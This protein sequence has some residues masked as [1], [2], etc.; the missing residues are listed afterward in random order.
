MVKKMQKKLK[1]HDLS[2]TSIGI[3]AV[4]FFDWVE[5]SRCYMG[6][7]ERY[8]YDLYTLLS[9]H[10]A[11]IKVVQPSTREFKQSFKDMEVIGVGKSTDEKDVI[12][13]D[14]Q[15]AL[16]SATS[17]CDITIYFSFH[18]CRDVRDNSISISHGVYWDKDR[19]DYQHNLS[20]IEG[21]LESNTTIVS[22]D[23][24]TINSIHSLFPNKFDY[25]KFRYIPNYVD[26]SKFYPK[27]H[28]KRANIDILFPRRG[29]KD[30][31]I[32]VTLEVMKDMADE[33]LTFTFCGTVPH[34]YSNRVKYLI[35]KHENISHRLEDM[36]DM[37]QV[38][39]ETDVSIIPTLNSEGISLSLLEAMASGHIV[40]SSWTGGLSNVVIDGFNGFLGP[41]SA[42]FIKKR[43]SYIINN[44]SDRML[45]IIRERA[46]ETALRFDM[47]YWN[48]KWM[49]LINERK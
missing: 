35:S 47:G 30:R 15:D 13:K 39:Q 2:N 6:G 32:E 28:T 36:E 24:N 43:L 26:T 45:S 29:T 3:I 7:G 5:P 23:T 14:L 16:H 34:P 8:L 17:S 41:P 48:M 31:G 44:R 37:P 46:I 27:K 12:S 1:S 22:C 33:D 42:D 38:Y 9:E 49:E 11:D 40:I 10:G 19:G 21:M 18:T 4:Q 25:K 20:I